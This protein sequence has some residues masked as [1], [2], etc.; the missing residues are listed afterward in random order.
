M[1]SPAGVAHA[2]SNLVAIRKNAD[3]KIGIL[4]LLSRFG[5]FQVWTWGLAFFGVGAVAVLLLTI[6][7][8]GARRIDQR[9]HRATGCHAGNWRHMHNC[10][11]RQVE[12][13]SDGYLTGSL[14]GHSKPFTWVQ[15]LQR[16]TN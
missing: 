4:G 6:V 3:P 12:T 5:G 15:Q 1:E 10:G 8:L 2:R 13:S 11:P 9:H 7:G 14:I 16:L